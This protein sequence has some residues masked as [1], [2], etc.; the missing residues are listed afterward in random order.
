VT[1]RPHDIA[2]L[3]LAPVALDIEH[4]LE[5][6]SGLSAEEVRYRVILGTDREPRSAKEREDV[7]L[8]TLTSGLD[9]HG[10]QV[11]RHPR[12]LLLSHDAYSLVLGLPS[13]LA[14]Y[15]DA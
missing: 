12:G 9:L 10:W 11:S 6:L 1:A 13:N 5:E 14:S 8:E 3:Y 7:L 4:R 2:D 15:L